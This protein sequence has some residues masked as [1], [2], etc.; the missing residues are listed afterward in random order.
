MANRLNTIQQQLS[1]SVPLL[2]L[3]SVSFLIAFFLTNQLVVLL[4]T[5]IYVTL[6]GAGF[7]L[8]R[9]ESTPID[10]TTDP[11]SESEF[12]QL[13]MQLT[14]TVDGLVRATQAMQEVMQQ[15]SKS[16][17]EQSTVVHIATDELEGFLQLSETIST[18]ILNITNISE[19]AVERSS[20]GQ[21]SIEASLLTM[22]DIRHQVAKISQTIVTLARLTQRIDEIIT[23]VS[24]IAT[25]SNLL[26]LNASIEAARAGQHGRGFAVVADEVRT[27]AQQS[28]Q[29]AAQIRNILLQIQTAMKDTVQATQIGMQQVDHGVSRTRDANEV[30]IALAQSVTS[31]RQVVRQIFEAIRQQSDGMDEISIQ[32]SRIDRITQQNVNNIQ[33]VNM[34]SS[35]L[36]RMADDLQ[37]TVGVNSG[38]EG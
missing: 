21:A 8:N 24:E 9:Q 38:F 1:V 35:N 25:Q 23:S 36:T 26:A 28:N 12:E 22:D 19:E 2:A 20:S 6:T 32:L 18:H 17:D 7:M 3:V 31:S 16:A 13:T 11:T 29:S 14:V 27:L 15:Q 5:V 34:V 30:M 37:L 10:A 33:T 4:F